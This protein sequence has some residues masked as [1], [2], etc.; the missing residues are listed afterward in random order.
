MASALTLLHP[1]ARAGE[2]LVSDDALLDLYDGPPSVTA[3]MITTVDGAATGS[4]ERTGSIN[5]PADLRVFSALRTLADVILVGAGTVRAEG[6]RAPRLPAD[7]VAARLARGLAPQPDLAV[8]SASG[9][10]PDDLLADHPW[11][12]TTT[13]SARL[14][15]ALPADRLVT[16]TDLPDVVAT[17]RA[18]G[19]R[20]IV[21][22]GGPRLLGGLAAAGLVD[23][24]CVTVAPVLV[25]GPAPRITA[26]DWFGPTELDL[27][28]LLESDGVLLIRWR[29][30]PLG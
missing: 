17:V 8:V 28:H 1:P 29:V 7:R 15:A 20:R 10:L 6:Y 4:D 19:A 14:R 21:T 2:V 25:G 11:V 3:S 16:T 13:P 24:A 22:E 30:R 9:D 26:T 18:A 27:V 12:F 5:G 23:E